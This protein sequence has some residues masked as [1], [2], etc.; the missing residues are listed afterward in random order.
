LPAPRPVWRHGADWDQWNTAQGK[1][2]L[3]VGKPVQTLKDGSAP[4]CYQYAVYGVVLHGR[5]MIHNVR[6]FSYIVGAFDT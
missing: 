3:N 1:Q 4:E 6:K 2:G 5:I